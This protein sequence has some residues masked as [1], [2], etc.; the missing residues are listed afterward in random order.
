M[1]FGCGM[2]LGRDR[3]AALGWLSEDSGHVGGDRVAVSDQ[4]N[5]CIER[6]PVLISLSTI[7]A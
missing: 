3:F 5:G 6:R 1:T 2:V 7:L 4:S